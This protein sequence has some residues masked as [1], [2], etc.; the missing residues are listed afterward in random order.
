VNS[1][2]P[3]TFVEAPI[4]ASAT[5]GIAALAV[6]FLGLAQANS[7]MRDGAARDILARAEALPRGGERDAALAG[8]L[9]VAE[10]SVTA[11]PKD[12]RTHAR[13][14]RLYYLQA[15]TAAVDDV[16]EPL[17]DAASRAAAE[18]RARSPHDASAE[19][20]TALIEIARSGGVVSESA[21]AA[22]ARSYAA[23]VS[24]EG[25]VWRLEAAA[26][27]WNALPL[28]L[29][30]R[31]KVDGCVQAGHDRAFAAALAEVARALPES[32]LGAC[33]PATR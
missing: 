18:A 6:A 27:T 30:E 21:T 10:D 4:A 12:A 2:R 16:S 33:A 1:I 22:V 29:Q 28:A 8:A 11:S 9:I 26:R 5:F 14:A 24:P 20:L 25:A 15:T 19:A 3:I 17:L 31:V 23:P 13:A 7:A 32:G